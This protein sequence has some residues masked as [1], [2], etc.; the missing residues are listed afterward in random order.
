[1]SPSPQ[2]PARDTIPVGDIELHDHYLPALP[3]GDYRIEATHTL[4][5]SADENAQVVG[6]PFRAVQR[7]TVR[8]PQVAIDTTAV[9]ARQPPEASGGRFAEVLPHLVLGDPLLPWERP[10][11]GASRTTPWLALLVLTDDQLIGG[12]TAP[13]RTVS[14]TV[15]GFLA[16]DPAVLKPDPPLEADIGQ[17]DP[18][19]FIEV[20]TAV[21]PE[22]APRLDEM[23][24]LAHSRGA[25][26]GDRPI[27]GIEE[28]GLFS[29]VV[30]NRFPAAAPPGSP[31]TP[32]PRTSCTWSPWRATR[33]FSW[34]IR[35]S[36]AVRRSRCCPCAAGRSGPT[37][38]ATRTSAPSP[39]GSPAPRTA[40][41]RRPARRCG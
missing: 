17:D 9:V 10:L 28:D 3:A 31:P 37:P 32:R 13:T 11:R 15:G 20:P 14:T 29:V 7:F 22:V 19:D 21:F 30:A 1:M 27:L 23:R 38:T 24:Y 33:G 2:H 5:T 6:V 8:A 41:A 26:T 34:T 16:P 35:T 36:R 25:N 39:R 4:R 18:C 40:P 12:T